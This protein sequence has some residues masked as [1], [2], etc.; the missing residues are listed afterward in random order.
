MRSF[1]LLVVAAIAWS[2]VASSQGEPNAMELQLDKL[3][4]YSDLVVDGIVEKITTIVVP[5]G[6][7]APGVLGPDMPIAIILFRVNSVLLGYPQP[8][9]IEIVA[10]KLGSPGH[11][12]FDLQEGDRYI[13]NLQYGDTGKLFEPGRYFTRDDSERFLIRNSEW[14]QGRKDRPLA[15]GE[16]AVLYDA[17]QKVADERSL[18]SLTRRADLIVRGKV[19]EIVKPHDLTAMGQEKNIQ[20]IRLMVESTMKG[21]VKDSSI[22]ISI[23]NV[24]LYKPSWRRHVSD[25]HIG[26]E[27]IAFLKHAEEPGYY[28]FA[29]VNGMFMIKGDKVIRNNNNQLVTTYSPKQLEMEAIK[30]AAEGE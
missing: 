22:V 9:Y 27:W 29:G 13:L 7:Y 2:S 4:I 15:K 26:E 20:K 12:C 8:E 23:I 30:A 21:E 25:M 19:I 6:D 18:E 3:F 24:G 16:L 17:I 11:Y 10:R 28:P 5:P 1:V 14:I